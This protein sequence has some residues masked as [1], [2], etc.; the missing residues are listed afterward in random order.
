MRRSRPDAPRCPDPASSSR[1]ELPRE[2]LLDR[3]RRIDARERDTEKFGE[4]SNALGT[5]APGIVPVRPNA[6]ALEQSDTS[7]HA[8][9]KEAVRKRMFLERIDGPEE[10]AL[11]ATRERRPAL[12][13]GCTGSRKIAQRQH[14]AARAG[15]RRE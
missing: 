15:E 13:A 11:R 7:R 3:M 10:P 4:R 2:R 14:D 8:G 1:T 5:Q 12:L 6:R 9:A